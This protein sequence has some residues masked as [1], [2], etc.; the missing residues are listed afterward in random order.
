GE[1]DMLDTAFLYDPQLKNCFP[2]AFLEFLKTEEG[3]WGKRKILQRGEFLSNVNPALYTTL[4]RKYD[5]DT[6]MWAAL[7]QLYKYRLDTVAKILS[8]H[9]ANFMIGSDSPSMN[10]YT[11]PPGY[12]GFLEM[13]HWHDAGISLSQIFRAATLSNAKAI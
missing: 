5:S 12:N 4:R 13:K 2:E 7:H 9:N 11:N 6:A 10:M 1:K 8:A 3:Q